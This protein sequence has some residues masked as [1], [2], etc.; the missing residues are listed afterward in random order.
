MLFPYRTDLDSSKSVG[1]SFFYS[2]YF[3]KYDIKGVPPNNYGYRDAEMDLGSTL[4]EFLIII[5]IGGIA[6]TFLKEISE[7]N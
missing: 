1:R 6:V 7:T 3:N 2:S 4:I 5:S